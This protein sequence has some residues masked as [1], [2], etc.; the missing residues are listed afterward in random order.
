MTE[1]TMKTEPGKKSHGDVDPEVEPTEQVPSN[2]HPV[3]DKYIWRDG[4]VV[5]LDGGK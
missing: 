4:V 2:P 3:S 5:H 1:S